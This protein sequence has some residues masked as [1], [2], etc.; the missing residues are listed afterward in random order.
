MLN[1]EARTK[2]PGTRPAVKGLVWYTEVSKTLREAG[3]RSLWVIFGERPSISLGKYV[4]VFRP[5]YTYSWPVLTKFKCMLDQRNIHILLIV[6]MGGFENSSV[7]HNN[8]P[9]GTTVPKG[10]K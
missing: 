8:V 5:R 9:T 7:C 4:I 3:A 2:G 1:R 6:P 10:V